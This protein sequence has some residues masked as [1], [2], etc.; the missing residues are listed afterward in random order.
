MLPAKRL[1][2]RKLRDANRMLRFHKDEAALHPLGG[3]GLVVQLGG[4]DKHMLLEAA[5]RCEDLGYNEVNLNL[6]CPAASVASHS[7]GVVLMRPSRHGQLAKALHHMTSQLRIPVSCKVRI[8]VDEHDSFDFFRDFV[9]RL[10]EE[11][12]VN[13]FVVLAAIFCYCTSISYFSSSSPSGS[14]CMRGKLWSKAA[15]QPT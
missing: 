3:G 8:G 5:L 4:D 1:A 11:G 9:R 12:G 6:G 7:H 2:T 15:F 13:R 14:S 10:H